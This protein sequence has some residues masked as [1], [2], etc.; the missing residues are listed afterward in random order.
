VVVKG[1]GKKPILPLRGVFV[2]VVVV[3]TD[4]DCGG[5]E[6]ERRRQAHFSSDRC[7]VAAVSAIW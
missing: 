1:C 2:V 6:G 3:V 5:N 4:K 7:F